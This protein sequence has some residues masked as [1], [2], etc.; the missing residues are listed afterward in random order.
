MTFIEKIASSR[1]FYR[2]LESL[3]GILSWTLLLGPIILAKYKPSWVAYF[4]LVYSV[5]WVYNSTKFVTL[6][7]LGHKKLL[8]VVKQDWLRKVQKKFPNDYD[9]YYYCGLIPFASE[10]LEVIR[11]TVQSIVDSN[12][13]NDKKILCLSSEKA[14]PRGFEFAKQLKE[15]FSKDFE[16]IFI[17]EHELKEGEIKGKSAN[18]N[19]AARYLYKELGKLGISADKVLL[20]SNDADMI[21]HR[22]FHA[23]LLYKFLSEGENKHT[24]IYQSIPVDYIDFWDAS[25]FTRM[26]W[27]IGL[28]FQLYLHQRGDYRRTVYS[29]YSMSLKTLKDMDFWDTDLIPEDERTMFK[30]IYTFGDAFK[31]IP[32]FITAKGRPVQAGSKWLTFKEQYKQ[33]LR[34]TW[35]ASEFANSFSKALQYKHISWRRKTLPILNQLRTHIEWSTGSI[36]PLFGGTLPLL[37]NEEFRKTTLAYTL[38]SILSVL[39]QIAAVGFIVIIYI[40]WRLA[41]QRPTDRGL[42]FKLF[43]V[44]QWILLPYVGFALNAIPA[45]EAQ[46]RLMF[47]KRIVYVESSK[48]K[49]Q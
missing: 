32:L 42:F 9:K 23:Y 6:A 37:L 44:V 8:Y 10:S 43:S 11:D 46:T 48:E 15:E 31:V 16:H 2:F 20:T 7:Y 41:P 12:Y 39:M 1:R 3:P 5:Y 22:Q 36:L 13:P 21:N 30:A 17:T 29:F 19:H 28:N 24:R 40:E 45:L 26:I 18:Q 38:P 47:N 4:V 34:W 49:K 14:V 35:G 33:I 27:T 25:F